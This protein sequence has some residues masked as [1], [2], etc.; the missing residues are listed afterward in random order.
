MP[1]S[2]EIAPH[3]PYLRR[4]ARALIGSQKSG[5]AYVISTLEALVTDPSIFPRDI[6]PHAG[7]YRV[8][9]RIW[10]SFPLNHASSGEAEPL[11]PEQSAALRNFALLTPASRQAFLLREVEGFSDEDVGAILGVS[12]DEVAE[13]MRAAGQEISQSIATD[14]LVI[15]DEMVIAAEISFIAKDL[16]HRVIGVA[17][18]HQEAT[19]L[20]KQKAPGLVLADIQLADGSSGLEAVNEILQGYEVPVIFITAYPERLLTGERPEPTFLISKPYK[21][22]AV[23]ATISQ[24]LFFDQKAIK[25][26]S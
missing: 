24:A 25:S 9:T 10:G 12:K 19:D 8:F 22:E 5:D 4:Y 26:R 11:K 6:S 7:L 15:E 18:T 1:L 3:L 17:R 16:G 21:V 2:K 23:K 20:V 13:M 14:V